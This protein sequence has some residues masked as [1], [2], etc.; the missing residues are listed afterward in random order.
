VTDDPQM[1]VYYDR[2]LLASKM[3]GPL[4]FFQITFGEQKA[5]VGFRPK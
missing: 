4:G 2:G 1:G 3:G 5:E